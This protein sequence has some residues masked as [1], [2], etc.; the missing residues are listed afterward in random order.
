MVIQMARL[1]LAKQ[2]HEKL[3]VT[4][5]ASR[6]KCGRRFRGKRNRKQ[7]IKYSITKELSLKKDINRSISSPSESVEV[8]DLLHEFL[9]L[10]PADFQFFLS[11]YNAVV[12]HPVYIF[13]IDQVTVITPGKTLAQTVL[14]LTQSAEFSKLSH[15]RMIDQLTICH[16]DIQNAADGHFYCLTLQRQ[17]DCL[18]RKTLTFFF[19]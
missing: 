2:A 11:N 15:G 16:L 12:F 1:C 19:R 3:N 17:H 18:G 13:Q 14:Q 4:A 5:S 7:E 6:A 9:F 8:G 10:G